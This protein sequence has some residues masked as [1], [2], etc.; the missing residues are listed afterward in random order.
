MGNLAYVFHSIHFFLFRRRSVSLCQMADSCHAYLFYAFSLD[1]FA[2]FFQIIVFKVLRSD[3]DADSSHC[4]LY[5]N[6]A[7]RV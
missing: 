5:E 4:I 3:C 2:V 1:S 6:V 7:V